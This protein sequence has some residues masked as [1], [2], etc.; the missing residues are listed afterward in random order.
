MPK[1]VVNFNFCFP[2][3]EGKIHKEVWVGTQAHQLALLANITDDQ[4]KNKT[5]AAGAFSLSKPRLDT[6]RKTRQITTHG[7][8]LGVT[9]QQL[10]LRYIQTISY[11]SA[12]KKLIF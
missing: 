7:C 4:F 10:R 12:M 9:R 11:H 8:W 6:K 3:I 1:Q 5:S 2:S